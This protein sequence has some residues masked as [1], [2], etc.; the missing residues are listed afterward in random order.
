MV[1]AEEARGSGTDSIG[2]DGNQA[3]EGGRKE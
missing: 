1:L 3:A 2:H